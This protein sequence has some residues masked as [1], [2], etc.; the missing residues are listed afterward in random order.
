[1]ALLS[2][3]LSALVINASNAPRGQ[4][5]DRLHTASAHTRT[6]KHS[7]LTAAIYW[8]IR[9][10]F[11]FTISMKMLDLAL[12]IRKKTRILNFHL[13]AILNIFS[14]E[15]FLSFPIAASGVIASFLIAVTS[16]Y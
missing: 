9:R 6:G 16:C 13:Y 11:S 4:N 1:M 5:T 12:R 7:Q 8:S 3:S 14:A 15:I 2:L 10:K